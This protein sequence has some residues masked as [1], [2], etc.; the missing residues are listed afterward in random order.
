VA[1]EHL[2]R[3]GLDRV[4]LAPARTLRTLDARASHEL[5]CAEVYAWV[6]LIPRGGA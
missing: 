5:P 1:L 2:A 3:G 4:Y 6:E